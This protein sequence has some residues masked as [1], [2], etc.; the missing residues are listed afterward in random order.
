MLPFM[1]KRRRK[2]I[3]PILA[4]PIILIVFL[5]VLA[6]FFVLFPTFVF[7]LKYFT[8]GAVGLIMFGVIYTIMSKFVNEYIA[9]AVISLIIAL[10]VMIMLREFSFYWLI[11]IAI[12]MLVAW[13]VLKTTGITRIFGE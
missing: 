13:S 12:I 9:T 3:I 11:A 4:I 1:N 2:G 10:A 8:I 7:F 6:V 5:I